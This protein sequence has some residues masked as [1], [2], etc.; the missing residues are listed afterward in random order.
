MLFHIPF[1]ILKL[2]IAT[3]F[4]DCKVITNGFIHNDRSLLNQFCAN[5]ESFGRSLSINSDFRQQPQSKRDV[6]KG[7]ILKILHG[8]V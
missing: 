3:I 1:P 4:I 8:S 2:R 5:V 7:F 6:N